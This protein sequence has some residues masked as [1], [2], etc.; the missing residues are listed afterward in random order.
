ML[1]LLI[2]VFLLF[3]IL[4]F[5]IA[6]YVESSKAEYPP[7]IACHAK[8]RKLHRT[9]T[10]FSVLGNTLEKLGISSEIALL[11]FL[12][13]LIP[14]KSEDDPKLITKNVKF[15]GV[16]VRVYQPRE[17]SAKGRKAVMF[18][19]GGGF[20]FGD[21]DVYDKLCRHISKEAG[22][23]VVSVGYRLAPKHQYPA[24]FEDCL[25]ATDHL[26]KNAQDYG[27]D[28]SSVIICGDSAGGNLTA[29][30]SQALVTR[31]DVP[32]LLAQ[33]LIYPSVQKIDFNLPSY[34]Q[35][36]YVPLLFRE[37]T[38]FY[39]LH[40]VAQGDLSI[41][42]EVQNGSHVPPDLR[43]KFSKWLSADNIPD[44]FK[45]RGYKPHVMSSFDKNL[46]E[47]LKHVFEPS[48]SP[49][50][51]EDSVFRLLPKTYILTCEFDV[52]CNDGIL[53]KK[54]LEDNGVSVTWHHVKDGFHGIFSFYDQWDCES[55]KLA[56]DSFVSFI[57]DA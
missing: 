24:A 14:I 4:C 13:K 44:E 27:V 15:E 53:Y 8:L 18:F 38:L 40:Y 33:V 49:L 2:G 47:K 11:N 3:C 48:S 43:K 39:M 1:L 55:G 25:N 57:R 26:L 6:V 31:K 42:R 41:S 56:V 5:I 34:Q 36:Q 22:V 17:S 7:G 35:N 37:R 12:R 19:H 20:V 46:Y 23:V 10:V 51:A 45:L 50:L 28:P 54:R 16:P 29:C 32:K 21:I 9:L 30:V 52:L